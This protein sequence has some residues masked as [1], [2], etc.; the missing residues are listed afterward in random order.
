MLAIA[1]V[2]AS[3][4][5]VAQK[6]YFTCAVCGMNRHTVRAL[7]FSVKDTQTDTECSHWYRDNVEPQHE[8]IWVRGTWSEGAIPNCV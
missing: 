7:S 4:A 6:R 2:I 3:I 1:L 8:H 5:P